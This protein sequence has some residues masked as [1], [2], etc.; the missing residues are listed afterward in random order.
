M[1]SARL[2]RWFGMSAFSGQQIG[3]GKRNSSERGRPARVLEL[4]E[5]RLAPAIITVTTLTDS[6]AV[7]GLVS[8]REA[9]QA[10]ETDAIV[11]GSTAGSGSDTIQFAAGLAGTINI[12]GSEASNFA[13]GRA[14][15]AITTNITIN[16]NNG[17]TGITIDTAA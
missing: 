2:R 14:A 10:A 9:I 8:L 12:S 17:S 4:L 11:D 16:G 6:T 1:F 15:F 7:N 5:D 3:K 13:L